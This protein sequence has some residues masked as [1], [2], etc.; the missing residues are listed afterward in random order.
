MYAARVAGTPYD[1]VPCSASDASV[2]APIVVLVLVAV[3]GVAASAWR[4]PGRLVRVYVPA[5]F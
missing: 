3:V 5:D 4:L 2:A 1:D